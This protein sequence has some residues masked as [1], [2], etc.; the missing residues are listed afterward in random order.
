LD[1][2]A[3]GIVLRF[4]LLSLYGDSA[5]IYPVFEFSQAVEKVAFLF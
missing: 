5:I 3:T 4:H 1:L 2:T